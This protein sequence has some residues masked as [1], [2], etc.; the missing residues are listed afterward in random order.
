MKNKLLI[1]KFK[2]DGEE[3]QLEIK[4]IK[5]S[6]L[7]VKENT[8]EG[9]IEGYASVFGNIDCYGD[10]VQK[11]AFEKCIKTYFPRYPKFIWS[12]NWEKVMGTVL[13]VKEDEHGLYFKAQFTLSVQEAR[14][15][16]E[17]IKAGAIT[18]ISFGYFVNDFSYN[19]DDNRLLK[20]VTIYEISPVLVGANEE[21]MITSVKS[22]DNST[23]PGSDDPPKPDDTP[24]VDAVKELSKK[25]DDLTTLINELNASGKSAGPVD[26]TKTAFTI[27][28]LKN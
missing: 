8:E 18:D 15:K 26:G 27:F 12:H 23:D 4:S 25:I 14:E 9:V 5:I 24:L 11:G 2:I 17:L 16:Y 13:E 3:K 10:I 1:K 28:K 7:S 20:E 19:K 22:A 21:A 6:E